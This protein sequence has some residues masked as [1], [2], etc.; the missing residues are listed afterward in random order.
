MSRAVMPP[1]GT[2]GKPAAVARTLCKK[3]AVFVPRVPGAAVWRE[4]HAASC[5]NPY[6]PWR[7]VFA[8]P[9]PA[10]SLPTVTEGP[11]VENPRYQRVPRIHPLLTRALAEPQRT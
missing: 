9:L 1:H 10:A 4:R 3:R 8:A 11:S 6:Q 5:A 2:D 7:T